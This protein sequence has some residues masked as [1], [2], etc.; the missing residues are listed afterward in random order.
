MVY[1]AQSY[2]RLKWTRRA[3]LSSQFHRWAMLCSFKRFWRF[4]WKE[5]CKSWI[6]LEIIIFHDTFSRN[7]LREIKSI[8][9]ITWHW[10]YIEKRV[11][12]VAHVNISKVSL[13]L[14]L[15]LIEKWLN[16]IF[17]PYK[18]SNLNFLHLFSSQTFMTFS[19][20][21]TFF[22]NSG[23]ASTWTKPKSLLTLAFF[24]TNS[25]I[26][27]ISRLLIC[28]NFR[29]HISAENVYLN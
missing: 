23:N 2:N 20:S 19:V 15:L 12:F 18:L 13:S 26:F 5:F 7:R 29:Y 10:H 28:F 3:L 1:P 24:P 4:L 16:S 8:V 9:L 22:A 6:S 25:S 21:S 27:S 11:I 14:F 17:S